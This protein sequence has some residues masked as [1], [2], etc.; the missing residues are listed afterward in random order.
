LW[1]GSNG[2]FRRLSAQ[3][4]AK[5]A[6]RFYLDL[7]R[8]RIEIMLLVD[9]GKSQAQPV[10]PWGAFKELHERYWSTLALGR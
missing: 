3:T 9:E 5:S 1:K 6:R 8:Q 4:A 2:A 7:Y 10:K